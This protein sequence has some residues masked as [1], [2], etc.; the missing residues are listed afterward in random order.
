MRSLCGGVGEVILS[1]PP[2]NNQQTRKSAETSQSSINLVYGLDSQD[3]AT[4]N[5]WY[6]TQDCFS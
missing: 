4:A 5:G 3:G 6:G 1:H 2:Y